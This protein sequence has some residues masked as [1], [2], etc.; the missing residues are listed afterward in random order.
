VTDQKLEE[1]VGQLLR[2]GVTLAAGLVAA[3]G[4]WYLAAGKTVP[5]YRHFVPAIQSR[6][7][8]TALPGPEAL[9]LAG[10]LLLIG[11]PVARVVFSLVAFALERDAPMWFARRLCW[12]CW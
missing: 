12:W 7:M 11:T 5:N 9:I 1:I 10:I 6:R 4:V 8:V 3:G 2:W